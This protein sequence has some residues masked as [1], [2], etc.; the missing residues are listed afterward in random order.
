MAD[1]SWRTNLMDKMVTSLR[2]KIGVPFYNAQNKLKLFVGGNKAT[3]F[4][5]VLHAPKH[6]TLYT[7]HSI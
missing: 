2:K 6:K 4:P 7:F 3:T 5:H 1:Y